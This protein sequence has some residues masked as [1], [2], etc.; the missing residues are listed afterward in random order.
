MYQREVWLFFIQL[1]ADFENYELNASQICR[2]LDSKL[3]EWKEILGGL[4]YGTEG[5]P[6][7]EQHN[8]KMEIMLHLIN[9]FLSSIRDN[10]SSDGAFLDELYSVLSEQVET[11][12]KGLDREPR[13]M[14]FCPQRPTTI[15]DR[16]QF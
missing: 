9:S 5:M 15:A 4:E 2:T 13:K 14:S 7:E 16:D 12:N 6:E 8:Y 3:T 11:Y 10:E 1:L